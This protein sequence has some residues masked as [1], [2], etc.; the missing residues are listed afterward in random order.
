MKTYADINLMEKPSIIMGHQKSKKIA[1]QNL[2]INET[3]NFYQLTRRI[4]AENNLEIKE[5][6]PIFD[7]L[8]FR[9]RNLTKINSFNGRMDLVRV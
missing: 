9:V 8:L 6:T 2:K 7:A 4:I 3:E 1:I 5:N